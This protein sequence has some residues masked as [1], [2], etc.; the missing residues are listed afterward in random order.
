MLKLS[1]GIDITWKLA[2]PP[3]KTASIAKCQGS[4]RP[5]VK[6]HNQWFL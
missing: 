3:E 6:K 1:V 5:D 2:L 4:I